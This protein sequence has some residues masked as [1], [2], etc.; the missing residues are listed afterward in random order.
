MVT[1]AAGETLVGRDFGS[2]PLSM[3]ANRAPTFNATL[4]STAFAGALYYYDPTASDPDNDPVS[5]DLPVHPVGM[6]V[7]PTL[8][9]IVWDPT[10]GQIGTHDV[11]LRAR[12]DKGNVSLLPFQITVK[13]PN[14]APVIT[15]TP[16]AGP[17]TVGLPFRYQVTAQDEGGGLTYGLT[18]VGNMAI[19]G[20]GLFSWTPVAGDVGTRHVVIT[21]TDAGAARA[22]RTF[23]ITVAATS[24]KRR[25]PD[26]G[27]AA[28]FRLAR[29]DLPLSCSGPRHK[30]RPAHLLP[31][32]GA[33][34]HD[35]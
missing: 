9:V 10:F 23:D 20:N 32:R 22:L 29:P 17:A 27:H 25:A 7:H 8:G 14:A 13:A 16:P 6:A 30:R 31:P 26:H 15:S 28:N 3:M 4:R 35:D 1:V 11:V 19:D 34:G 12:D 5:F 24:T 2:K 18:G 21:V 33:R